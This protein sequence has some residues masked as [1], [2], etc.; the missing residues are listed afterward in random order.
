L[1]VTA[2]QAIKKRAAGGRRQTA[3]GRRQVAGGNL[4]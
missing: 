3:G 4:L 1:E 2:G